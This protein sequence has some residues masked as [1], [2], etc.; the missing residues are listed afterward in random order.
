MPRRPRPVNPWSAFELSRMLPVHQA[1]AKRRQESSV[2]P[3]PAPIDDPARSGRSAQRT[4]APP[5]DPARGPT[6]VR[7][8]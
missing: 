6:N 2:P 5:V 8:F 4:K 1:A 7:D 3:P